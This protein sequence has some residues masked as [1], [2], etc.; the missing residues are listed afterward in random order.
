MAWINGRWVEDQPVFGGMLGGFGGQ[1]RFEEGYTGDTS[2]D[3]I[4]RPM[5]FP[6]V[7]R[8]GGVGD[9]TPQN[10]F[11]RPIYGQ[12]PQMQPPFGGGLGN[13]DQWNPAQPGIAT[14]YQ[15]PPSQNVGWDTGAISNVPSVP[16]QMYPPTPRMPA[17]VPPQFP[18]LPPRMTFDP[19]PSIK[20]PVPPPPIIGLPPLVPPVLP[21]DMIYDPPTAARPST[22]HEFNV[23]QREK[24]KARLAE[25]RAKTKKHYAKLRAKGASRQTIAKAKAKSKL[26]GAKIKAQHPTR[27]T[28]TIDN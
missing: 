24:T 5:P 21:P 14:Q 20:P 27:R 28:I 22:D 26:R 3:V 2:L 16:P 4:G 23:A 17:S 15:P 12:G 13:I 7:G 6:D 11:Q 19:P 8:G 9:P 18:S 25:D 1:P 10:P